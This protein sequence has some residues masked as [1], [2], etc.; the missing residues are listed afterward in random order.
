MDYLSFIKRLA[1][2]ALRNFT[3]NYN[4]ISDIISE[5][6][7]KNGICLN[8]YVIISALVIYRILLFAQ[9]SFDCNLP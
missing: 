7:I 3:Y 1:E 8:L 2:N 6:K 9:W 4:I 5:M